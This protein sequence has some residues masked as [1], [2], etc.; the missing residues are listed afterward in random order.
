MPR[1][2][3]FSVLLLVYGL[4]SLPAL[5]QEPPKPDPLELNAALVY[6]QAFALMPALSEAETKIRDD[7]LA[8]ERPVDEEAR[9]I[10]LKSGEAMQYL[11]RASQFE[12]AAWG[13]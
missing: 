5:G 3:V 8:T 4:S 9:K 1:C 12:K 6:W 10:V 13:I 7:V 2:F 11:H